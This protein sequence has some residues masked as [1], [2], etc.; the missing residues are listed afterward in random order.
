LETTEI[1]DVEDVPIVIAGCMG[2][3]MYVASWPAT[4]EGET[5]ITYPFEVSMD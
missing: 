3:I 1:L 5:M 4:T 2:N